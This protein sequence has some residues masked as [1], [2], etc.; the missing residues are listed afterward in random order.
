MHGWVG[1]SAKTLAALLVVALLGCGG[2]DGTTEEQLDE[3]TGDYIYYVLFEE[4]GDIE[5]EYYNI[6]ADGKGGAQLPGLGS[7]TYTIDADRTLVLDPG[8]GYE[9]VPGRV[10]TD[11]SVV[12]LGDPAYDIPEDDG[13]QDVELAIAIRKSSGH[14]LAEFEGAYHICQAGRNGNGYY[15]ARVEVVMEADGTG[16]W[17]ILAHSQ[18][19]MGN[20]DVAVTVDPSDGTLTVNNGMGTDAGMVSPDGNLFVMADG[21]DTD[22]DG[23]VMLGVGVRHDTGPATPDGRG[24]WMLYQ[25]AQSDSMAAFRCYGS[26]VRLD[27]GADEF[28][29]DIEAHSQGHTGTGGPAP[30]TLTGDGWLTFP[31]S[32][33]GGHVSRD[34]NFMAIAGTNMQ[35]EDEIVSALALK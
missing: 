20:G 34:G 21:D 32:T 24:V 25:L 19:N 29:Y 31:G 18:G 16:T 15:T 33:L 35:A 22:A 5:V 28:T 8:P 4:W 11:G 23:E 17:E 14:T 26:R 2:G 9:T 6:V 1:F 3:W 10:S 27:I 30:Y 13:D 7:L 12:L